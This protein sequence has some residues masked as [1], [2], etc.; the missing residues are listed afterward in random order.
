[1]GGA[2]TAAP[3]DA[4]GCLYWN[5]AGIAALP[6]SQVSVG[7]ELALPHQELTSRVPAD[8]LGPGFPPVTLEGTTTGEPGVVPLPSIGL[9]TMSEDSPFTFGLGIMSIAG[10]L[11]NYPGSLANPLLSNLPPL[12]LGPVSSRAEVL[13]LAPTVATRLTDRWSVGFAP[14]IDMARVAAEPLFLVRPNADGSFPPGNGTRFHWGGGFQLGVLYDTQSGWLFGAC[15]KSRQWFERFR[16][17]SEDELGQPRVVAIEADY[18]WIVS[19]GVSYTPHEGTLIAADFR[20]FDYKNADTFGNSGFTPAG[21]VAGLG[22]DSLGSLSLGL[23]QHLTDKLALQ[24]GYAFSGTPIEPENASFNI[25]S[26]LTPEHVFSIGLSHRMSDA[27][28]A[29]LTYLHFFENTVE[30]PILTPF[31]PIPGSLVRH[32]GSFDVLSTGFTV[33][34]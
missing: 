4:L 32:T 11:A 27:W 5:P 14:T 1:M 6:G 10:F 8:A 2:A 19:L 34:F 21:A 25:A 9:V 23:H 15:L 30:G 24:V 3:L 17:H 12:G 29:H 13:Q 20:Y 7:L 22:W 26:P 33:D 28:T 18:P 31:G 16:F